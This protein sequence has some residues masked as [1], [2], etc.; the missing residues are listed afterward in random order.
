MY[1]YLTRRGIAA[2]MPTWMDASGDSSGSTETLALL[3]Q[4]R[5]EA[6]SLGCE[7]KPGSRI[8]TFEEQLRRFENK[9]YNPLSDPDFDPASMSHG[10]RDLRELAF[11]CHT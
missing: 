7:I 5:T 11:I 2:S 1:W 6:R 10:A 9:N 4:L 3:A 8:A